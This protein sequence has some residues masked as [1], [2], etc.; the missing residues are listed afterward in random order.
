MK[1]FIEHDTQEDKYFPRILVLK[2]SLL[3]SKGGYCIGIQTEK[4]K[5]SSFFKIK[6]VL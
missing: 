1:S 3:R 6:I 5:D 4:I 2:K